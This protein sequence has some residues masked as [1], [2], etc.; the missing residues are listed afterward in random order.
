MEEEQTFKITKW[1]IYD[2]Y[3]CLFCP[4]ATL[5]KEVAKQHWNDKHAPPPPL[6][7]PPSRIIRV[8]RFGNPVNLVEPSAPVEEKERE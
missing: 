2:N 6:P 1:K 4:H 5:D 8:D 7:P 3:E